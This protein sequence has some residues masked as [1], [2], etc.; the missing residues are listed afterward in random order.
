MAEENEKMNIIRTIESFYPVM[1]GPANQAFMIS[2]K[3]SQRGF[4]SPIFTS[5]MGAAQSPAQEVIDG[6]EV[7]RFKTVYKL[8]KYNFTPSMKQS[9]LKNKPDIVH[10]HNYRS[11]QSTLG[12]KMAKKLGVPFIINTHG[13][14]LGYQYITRGLSQLPYS[15]YD[16]IGGRKVVENASAGIQ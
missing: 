7:R 10:S 16:F 6:V 2:K 5:D 15:I 4:N 12:Y 3:L 9:L 8:M 1:S 11:Y 14:L 13:S